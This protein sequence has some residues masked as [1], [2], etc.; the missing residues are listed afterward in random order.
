MMELILLSVV[1][2]SVCSRLCYWH[3]FVIFPCI[4]ALYSSSLQHIHTKGSGL[5]GCISTPSL[6][7]R[8]ALAK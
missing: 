8:L 1:Q 2:L 3:Q 5:E 6:G 4:Y 7:M